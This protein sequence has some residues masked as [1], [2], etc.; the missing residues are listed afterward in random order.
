PSTGILQYNTDN[1]YTQT[2]NELA[3]FRAH[4]LGIVYQTNYWVKSLNVLDNVALPLYFLG[5]TRTEAHQKAQIALNRVR[6][7]EYSKKY[8]ILLSGGEQQRVAMARALVDDSPVII[9]DEPTGNLD[10]KNGDTIIDLLVELQQDFGKTIIL[11]THNM[12]YLP[13]AH[14]LLQIQ[15]GHVTEIAKKDISTTV[16][17]LVGDVEKR[18]LKLTSSDRRK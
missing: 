16:K 12:E 5:F 14:H 2:K 7:G 9:A 6:M 15:D 4:E 11:V 3:Y 8:P 17:S 1:L 13:I 10:S 18:I